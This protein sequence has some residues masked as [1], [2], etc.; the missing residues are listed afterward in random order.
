MKTFRAFT[1]E[2]NNYNEILEGIIIPDSFD[3]N[4]DISRKND[5]EYLQKIS[6]K[7]IIFVNND[8]NSRYDRKTKK[9]ILNLNK[10]N[11]SEELQNVFFHESI[12]KIQDELSKG[13]LFS[14]AYNDYQY[15]QNKNKLLIEFPHGVHK[16]SEKMA[17]A[18]SFC[19]DCLNRKQDMNEY[20]E[21]TKEKSELFKNLIKDKY[22]RKQLGMYHL[23]LKEAFNEIIKEKEYRDQEHFEKFETFLKGI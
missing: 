6:T 16:I 13:L 21:V 8:S 14:K 19:L 22:F 11:N 15:R 10:I 12:H 3:L 4:I 7:D 17:Y 20:I 23:Y 9:I 1:L 5:I 18:A 2:L